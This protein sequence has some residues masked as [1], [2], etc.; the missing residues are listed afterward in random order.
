M[1]LVPR[2]GIEPPTL[3]SVAERDGQTL[4]LK[5]I[6]CQ[7]EEYGDVILQIP[8]EPIKGRRVRV[9]DDHLTSRS[10]L[11]R[12]SIFSAAAKPEKRD[13]EHIRRGSHTR[14][15]FD[16]VA[17]YMETKANTARWASLRPAQPANHQPNTG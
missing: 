11:G 16:P 13:A 5:L 8:R 3:G 17:T 6:V 2:D 12:G 4:D 15:P 9:Q 1:L 7:R 10:L 14:F